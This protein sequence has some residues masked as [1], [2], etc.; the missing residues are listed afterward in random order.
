MDCEKL[1]AAI[2]L[3]RRLPPSKINRNAQAV[4]SLIPDLAEDLLS[5]VYKLLGLLYF[6]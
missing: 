2:S 6:K 3:L 4:T 1:T 5:K